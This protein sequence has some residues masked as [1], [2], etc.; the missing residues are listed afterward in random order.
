PGP[1]GLTFI[2]DSTA[3]NAESTAR[4][5][6]SFERVWWIL[7]GKPKEGGIDSLAEYFP[8]VARAYLIGEASDAFA[9]TLEGRVPYVRCGTLEKAVARAAA[10]GQ[11]SDEEAPVILF[12]PACASFDQFRSFEHRGDVF[13]EVVAGL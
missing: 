6:A 2:N 12:S 10:D 5:L 1:E 8:R 4:A 13:R 3:T 7:G 11:A 9:Q